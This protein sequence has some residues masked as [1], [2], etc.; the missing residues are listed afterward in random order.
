MDRSWLQVGRQPVTNLSSFLKICHT[1]RCVVYFLLGLSW[2]W[3]LADVDHTF[4][5]FCVHQESY[6][7]SG[8]CKPWQQSDRPQGWVCTVR[9][10]VCGGEHQLF[11]KGC[12]TGPHSFPH[13]SRVSLLSR[14][15]SPI[16]HNQK[17]T[18][19]GTSG[20]SE[21]QGECLLGN[22]SPQQSCTCRY[23]KHPAVQKASCTNLGV[24]TALRC[25]LGVI[26]CCNAFG[27]AK[28]INSPDWDV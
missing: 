3:L 19:L 24:A 7:I 28:S 18:R 17:P 13:K 1:V 8:L 23:F 16:L 12:C 20:V 15:K 4:V 11:R 27:F 26:G 2:L 9:S 10:S 25:D 14:R 22:L 5:P 6:H 21:F